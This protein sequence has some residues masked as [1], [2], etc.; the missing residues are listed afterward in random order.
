ML[1]CLKWTQC[2]KWLGEWICDQA[3]LLY[4]A[5]VLK[6]K[7]IISRRSQ[8][9]A[10]CFNAYYYRCST[11]AIQTRARSTVFCVPTELFSLSNILCVTGGTITTAP[12]SRASPT[13]TSSCIR[14]T[15]M[16]SD[17]RPC[18]VSMTRDQNKDFLCQVQQMVNGQLI[19]SKWSVNCSS[20]Q[21]IGSLFW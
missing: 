1:R 7:P 17:V 18:F 21:D 20:P 4:F 3:N 15:R 8:V 13:S 19:G 5:I 9:S 16:R 12:P 6:I 11:C 14:K 2:F 10:C